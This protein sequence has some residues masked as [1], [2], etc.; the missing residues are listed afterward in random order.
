M[1]TPPA[2]TA[3]MPAASPSSRVDLPEPFSPTR[4]V[5]GAL[6]S[7]RSSQRNTG[8]DQGNVSG[9]GSDLRLMALRN[10]A[11]R[12][13]DARGELVG[14]PL[15]GPSDHA[16]DAYLQPVAIAAED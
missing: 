5:T 7:S 2:T 9:S 11:R 12:L 10:T 8:T 6:N 16:F 3:S 14:A 15:M 4:K 1:S 13:S